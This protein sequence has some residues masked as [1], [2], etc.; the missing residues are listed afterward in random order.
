MM[1]GA[2][3]LLGVALVTVAAAQAGPVSV[4]ELLSDPDRFRTQPVTVSGTMS[5]F[6]ERVTHRGKTPYYTFDFGDGTQTVRVVSYEKPQCRAGAATVE[7]TFE[8]VKWRVRVSYSYEEIRA[9]NVTC[10]RGDGPKTE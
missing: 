3:L 6:Q 9:W 5:H 4:G 2:L 8:Q 7:G 1:S 10:F